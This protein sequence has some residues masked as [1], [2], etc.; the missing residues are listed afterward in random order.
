MKVRRRGS[1]LKYH[2]ILGLPVRV[3]SSIDPGVGGVEGIVVNETMKTIEIRSGSRVVVTFKSGT[4]YLFKIPE[5]GEVVE[6]DG[7]ALLGRPEDRARRI[8]R[9]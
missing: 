8:L 7:D 3:V 1:N 4:R 6:I 9:W 5:T 2:E